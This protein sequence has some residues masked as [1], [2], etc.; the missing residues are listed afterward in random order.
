M[1]TFKGYTKCEV[2][3]PNFGQSILVC[4][5]SL[6]VNK[7]PTSS[8]ERGTSCLTWGGLHFLMIHLNPPLLIREGGLTRST[9][10]F[11]APFFPQVLRVLGVQRFAALNMVEML[12]HPNY[13]ALL[14]AKPVEWHTELYGCLS[15]YLSRREIQVCFLPSASAVWFLCPSL[16]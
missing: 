5:K 11:P 3:M 2:K 13:Q 1:V 16:Q 14:L 10:F 8:F 9:L 6:H 12:E 15:H 4:A 7:R